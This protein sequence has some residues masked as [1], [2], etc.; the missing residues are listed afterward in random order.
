MLALANKINHAAPKQFW[1]KNNQYPSKYTAIAKPIKMVRCST[2]SLSAQWKTLKRL[3][4]RD[5]P[6]LLGPFRPKFI[7][8]YQE[9]T[10]KVVHQSF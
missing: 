2:L 6:A 8:Y 10:T 7:L 5:L 3:K 1:M 4:Y 9:P